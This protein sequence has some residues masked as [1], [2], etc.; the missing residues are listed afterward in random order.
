MPKTSRFSGLIAA[1]HSPFHDDG[2]LRLDVISRQAELLLQAGVKTAFICGST[3]E[4]HSLSI[5]ERIAITQRWGEVA[6]GTELQVICHVGHNCQADA[7]ALAAAA[8]RSGAVAISALAPCYFKPADAEELVRFLAPIAAAAPELPF[9]FYDIPAMTGVSVSL[10]QFL[11]LGARQIPSLAGIKFTNS[12]STVLQECLQFADGGFEILYGVDECFLS[13][14]LYGCQG[15]VGSSY[16]F[17]AAIYYRILSSLERN[18]LE[19]A[20]LHQMNS[21]RLIQMLARVGYLPAAK[22][23]MK[24]L[25]VPVGPARSPLRRLTNEQLQ[26]LESQ[27]KDSEFWND[28]QRQ[29]LAA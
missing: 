9:Y 4:S 5:Q 28:L 8:S 26:R 1:T 15:A 13:G 17:A 29:S 10:P 3:G 25:G 16:N 20:R 7:Q 21:I 19:S 23:V 27:L 6:R 12:D 18:D 24:L 11:E 14:M 22:H 2:S